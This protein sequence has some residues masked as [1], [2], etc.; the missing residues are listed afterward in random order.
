MSILCRLLFLFISILPLEYVYAGI[1]LD[2]TRLIYNAKDAESS[3]I[4]TNKDINE[5]MIQSWIESDSISSDNIPFIVTPSLVRIDGEKQQ[6]LRL[7]YKGDGLPDD[8]E[9]VLWMIIQEIPQ[10]SKLE[11][12]ILLAVRQRIKMFYRPNKLNG[13]QSIAA[14]RLEFKLENNKG[15]IYLIINN[16]SE[17]HITIA[18]SKIYLSK[19]NDNNVVTVENGMINPFEVRRIKLEKTFNETKENIDIE[20]DSINDFGGL[21]RVKS[22]LVV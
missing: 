19:G 11:N 7:F 15:N 1:V 3:F 21:D 2:R 4:V 8:R 14:K 9:S 12:S 18:Q 10:K 17:Y 13:S 5:V 20:F 22:S 16:K 6:K